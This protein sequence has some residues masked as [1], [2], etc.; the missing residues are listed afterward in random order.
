MSGSVGAHWQ[1][2]FDRN[3]IFSSLTDPSADWPETA[4]AMRSDG[5]QIT[6]K[7]VSTS[8]PW[9]TSSDVSD[10]LTSQT[11]SAGTL[12]G[13]TYFDAAARDTETYNASGELTSITDRNGEVT[14]LTYGPASDPSQWAGNLIKVTDP[15][16]RSLSFTYVQSGISQ[17]KSGAVPN[18]GYPIY[19]VQT[20]TLPDGGNI[21]YS[22]DTNGNLVKV[23]YPDNS[24]RQYVYNEGALT[25]G[26]NLPNALTGDIDETGTRYT[27]IGYNAQGQATMSTLP[28][29][30]NQTQLTFNSSGTTTAQYALGAQVTLSFLTTSGSIHTNTVSGPC[31]PSCHQPNAS[32]TYDANGYLSSRTDFNGNV[33]KTTYDA[34][35]LLDQE[36]DAQGT[37][38]QR[39]ITTTWNTSLRVPLTRAVSN[40]GGTI[41]ASTQW[42]YNAI[43]QTL[44][45]C[46]IDPANSAA[47]GYSCS[48]TGAV[49]AGV[50]RW[51]YTYC[52]TVSSNCPLVGLILT[53]TGPRTDLTQTT[54]YSYYTSSSAVSCGTPGA[55]CYQ[56]GDLYQVTD[57]LSHVTTIASYD[58]DGR[59]TRTTD[60]NGVNTDMTYTQRGWL[61]SRTVGGAKTSFTYTPYGAVQTVTDPDGITTTYNY[62][63]AHRLNKITD[64]LGN[65]IQYTL[66]AAGDKTGEQIYDRGGD[67]HKS[68]ARKYNALGQLITVIDGLNNTVFSAAASNSYDA[69]GN[70]VLSSDALGVQRQLGYDALNRLVQTLDNY[71]GVDTATQN[72]KTAYGYDSLNRLSQV[73]DPSSLDTAYSYDGLGDATGQV[74]PDTGSTGNTFDAAGNLISKTDA[75]GVI[76]QYRYDA[77]NRLIGVSYPAQSALNITYTYDQA[78]PISGCTGYN[79][80]HR[81]GMTDASG[82][83]AWCYTNQGDIQEVRQ[84]IHGTWYTYGYAYTPGRR[85]AWLQYPSGFDLQY[86]HDGDGRI[87]TINYRQQS[88]PYGSY[89]NATLTPLVTNVTYLPFG[90]VSGYT[91]PGGQSVTRSYDANYRLTDLVSTGLTLHFLRDAKGRIQAEGN[92]AGANPPSETYQYDPLDRLTATLNAGGALEQ[93]LT[94]NPT[95]DRLST[96]T[97]QGTQTYTYNPGT[98]QLINIAGQARNVDVNGNTTAMVDPNGAVMGLGYD[99]RNRLTAVT[100][101][102]TTIATYQYNGD[103][104]RVWR[105]VTTPSTGQIATVYDPNGTGNLYG[106]YFTATNFR[107]YVYVDGIVMASATDAGVTAP[108]INNLYADHLGTLRAAL[109]TGGTTVYSWPWLNNAFGQQSYSGTNAFYSRFPGQYFDEETG[110]FYN[111]NRD[112]DSATGRYVESD[113]LGLIGGINSYAYVGTNPLNVADPRGLAYPICMGV[114]P[115]GSLA[116]TP[117]PN[118]SP[119]Y[120]PNLASNMGAGAEV[121][122]TGG[123]LLGGAV[124]A[125]IIGFPEVE[126][127]EAAAAAV[128]VEGVASLEAMDAIAGEPIASLA[129]GAIAGGAAGSVGGEAAGYALTPP[130]SPPQQSIPTQTATGPWD[131]G[132][133]P[134]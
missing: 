122:I 3:I 94:Y 107:E 25:G 33:T 133:C 88:G 14:T 77:L 24:V 82:T 130:M 16:G 15:R 54:T 105:T 47:T 23:T 40:A 28:S 10:Q 39:T 71:D 62:D 120:N 114:C 9:T 89:T 8:G 117:D 34:T 18:G 43:G 35:G 4:V 73:T 31:G 101:G 19:S 98:H 76:T 42:V 92:N 86:G 46:D 91:F 111:V 125:N 113:P 104:Q 70:L 7:S 17:P 68:L 36:V 102:S 84:V 85:V 52:S 63:A 126:L 95:G 118:A 124:V 100:S 13:W 83:T 44:A 127:G 12:M 26:T 93:S 2:N 108:G 66:D 110:L 123:A 119:N 87:T 37:S 81:T 6:F 22:Y 11:N 48:S 20:I 50:R 38:S 99:N 79:I 121:G 30:V 1:S 56:L 29:G 65:Y 51:A 64:A 115:V 103:G 109:T 61:A 78:T 129:I 53:A 58:A 57:A 132:D 116:L 134:N 41:V 45:R 72:T 80:G 27:S 131:T 90:P 75:R 112:Y 96:T 21:T 74:S 67:L 97:P 128:G 32:A 5:K 59:I 55:A 106:E 60:A 49:P 69:N